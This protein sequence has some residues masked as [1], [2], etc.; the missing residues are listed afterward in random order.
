[1]VNLN[2]ILC[3]I[4]TVYCAKVLDEPIQNLGQTS[5]DVSEDEA[6]QQTLKAKI[7]REYKI[8]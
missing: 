6:Q 2:G 8:G 3:L 1:M 7:L 4:G 5:L